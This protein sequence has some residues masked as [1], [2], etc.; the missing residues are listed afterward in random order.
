MIRLYIGGA[1]HGQE[2]VAEKE[3][4]VKPELVNAE[5]ALSA[6]GIDKFHLLTRQVLSEGGN[7][8]DFAKEILAKNPDAVICCDEI[9][10][11]LHPIERE[12]LIWR[13]ETGRA[14]CILAAQAESVTRVFCGVPQ[15]IK[16]AEKTKV[17]L[18]RHGMTPGNLKKQYIGGRSDQPLSEEGAEALKELAESG[19][20][21]RA[22]RVYVS[23]M[24]RC[25][26]TADILF[27]YALQYVVEGLREMD[28]GVF[29][30]RSA[31][32]ME[33]DPVYQAWVE[34]QCE[35]LIPDGENK[36]DFTDRC[37]EAFLQT[38]NGRPK[39]AKDAVFVIHGG[40]IMA[41][42]SRFGT[43]ER[44][45]YEWYVKNGHGFICTWDGERLKIEREI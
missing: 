23:P 21:P 13:E 41:I 16:E 27:P 28:F 7:A 29:E 26:E 25:S 12:D 5:E 3:T 36:A 20:Y 24:R 44:S 14:L 6:L 42:L 35:G 37:C 39:D 22:G 34:T 19:I 38:M 31:A 18:I 1:G 40:T 33:N 9:G 45:Y 4:G 10:S 17:V 8:Q 30:E 11:G 15:R 43:P 2:I 32:D